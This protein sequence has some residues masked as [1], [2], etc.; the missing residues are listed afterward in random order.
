MTRRCSLR[1]TAEVFGSCDSSYRSTSD[2]TFEAKPYLT[3]ECEG[4]N[5]IK[6]TVWFCLSS[7]RAL[8]EPVGA[9]LE[10]V[11]ALADLWPRRFKSTR[12]VFTLVVLIVAG[13]GRRFLDSFLV[14]F[15]L[16][17]GIHDGRL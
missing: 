15:L 3:E 10:I 5:R 1:P 13:P 7:T 14:S 6:C 9:L 11:F 8:L 12:I 2:E 17:V 16:F 4:L